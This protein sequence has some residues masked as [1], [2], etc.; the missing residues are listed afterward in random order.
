[1]FRP[2][3]ESWER[4]ERGRRDVEVGMLEERCRGRDAGGGEGGMK[5]NGGRSESNLRNM[6]AGKGIR[7]RRRENV[8]K[9]V[10]RKKRDKERRGIKENKEAKKAKTN[11]GE[12]LIK[13][14]N[15]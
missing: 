15:I 2:V 12:E 7:K 13:Y 1:M 5:R 4:W 9:N 11:Q 8:A 10:E 3:T 14:L 6:E